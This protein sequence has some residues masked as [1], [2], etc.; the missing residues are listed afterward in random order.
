MYFKLCII[1]SVISENILLCNRYYVIPKSHTTCYE[2]VVLSS[3]IT[4]FSDCSHAIKRHLLCG[5]KAMTNLDSVFKSRHITLLTKVCVVKVIVF[6]V[7][8]Y[9]CD[10]WTLKKVELL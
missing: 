3:K 9:G 8:M 1:T 2:D 5:R 7:V 4:V 6:L 10:S